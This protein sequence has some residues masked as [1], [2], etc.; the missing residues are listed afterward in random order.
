MKMNI[1]LLT[2]NATKI[3]AS[4]LVLTMILLV[5]P[6][7]TSANDSEVPVTHVTTWEQLKTAL[8][9]G[10]KNIELNNTEP[11]VATSDIN[12]ALTT[13]KTIEIASV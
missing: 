12:V 9:R 13:D 8:E 1:K 4:F 2:K 6:V 10:D 3:I 11:M 7:S 5:I